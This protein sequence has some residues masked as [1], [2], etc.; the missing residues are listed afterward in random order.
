MHSC[1]LAILHSHSYIL[2][3]GSSFCFTY[4]PGMAHLALVQAA[5]AALSVA[6]I[7]LRTRDCLTALRG[8]AAA[9][10]G[11]RSSLRFLD[12]STTMLVE[13]MRYSTCCEVHVIWALLRTITG[14]QGENLARVCAPHVAQSLSRVMSLN[15]RLFLHDGVHTRAQMRTRRAG[16]RHTAHMSVGWEAPGSDC[17]DIHLRFKSI[18]TNL[19]NDLNDFDGADFNVIFTE[20][21]QHVMV[22]VKGAFMGLSSPAELVAMVTSQSAILRLVTCVDFGGRRGFN[23]DYAGCW[24]NVI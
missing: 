13:D 21:F 10:E 17:A 22:V 11:M 20:L 18:L 7:S 2:S 15:E 1:N 9:L 6:P 4:W 14:Y 19:L 5:G 8:A 23:P 24:I 3:H 12:N 16:V